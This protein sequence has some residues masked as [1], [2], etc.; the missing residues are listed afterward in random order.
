MRAN[1]REQTREAGSNETT[2]AAGGG[3]APSAGRASVPVAAGAP[4][5]GSHV[6]PGAVAPGIPGM[7]DEAY[8]SDSFTLMVMW[9]MGL[10]MG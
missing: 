3:P 7:G 6:A 2:G 5:A 9:H 10:W 8:A 4:A 1:G